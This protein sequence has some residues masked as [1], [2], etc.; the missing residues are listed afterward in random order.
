MKLPLNG[1][2]NLS[3]LDGWWLESYNGKNGW[4]IGSEVLGGTPE[5]QSAMDIISLFNLLENQIV[6]LYYAKPDGRLPLAWIQSMRESMRTIIPL[7][8]TNR[9][10]EEYSRLLY[11]PAAKAFLGMESN[12][13]ERAR[14]LSHWKNEMTTL[15]PQVKVL[16]HQISCT[17]HHCS[18]FVGETV[19]LSASVQLGRINPE[20]VR[21][22]AYFGPVEKNM[23]V[24]PH[25]R[26]MTAGVLLSEG[27][28]SY[29]GEIPAAES[30][31][32]G[33]NIRVIPTHPSLVQAHELPLISWAK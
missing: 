19:S 22:Q 10:V 3:V 30:G 5:H 8:N 28:Y 1:G 24:A 7:F 12:H 4:A 11:E 32:Y 25:L 17:P 20:Y 13:F 18:F 23:I 26:E 15:W 16:E 6:P 2:I 33:L 9:M 21:V 31:V 29:S 14:E 27:I